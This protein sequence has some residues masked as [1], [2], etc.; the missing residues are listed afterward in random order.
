MTGSDSD[1]PAE[2]VAERLREAI[3]TEP[4]VYQLGVTVHVVGDQVHLAGPTST[5]A[6]RQ[7]I[8]ALVERLAP[9]LH[10]VDDLEVPSLPQPTEAEELR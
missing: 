9:E 10:V 2:Y 5:P 4:D 8:V 7:A 3:A 1:E 6:Q